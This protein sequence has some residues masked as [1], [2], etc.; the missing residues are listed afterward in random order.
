MDEDAGCIRCW[1]SQ[2]VEADEVS[3]QD[4]CL[5]FYDMETP[6]DGWGKISPFLVIN[7]DEWKSCTMQGQEGRIE[8][9]KG[10]EDR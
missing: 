4:G 1:C 7:R 5:R 2:I 3:I 8:T 10:E 9:V 6:K